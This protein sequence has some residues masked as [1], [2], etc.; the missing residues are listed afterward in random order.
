MSIFTS[1]QTRFESAREEEM[2]VQDYF[3]KHQG[4]LQA[5]ALRGGESVQ[6][7]VSSV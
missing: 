3:A 1:F 6:M 5:V 7:W 2:S 4:T